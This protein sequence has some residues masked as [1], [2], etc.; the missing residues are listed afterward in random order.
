MKLIRSESIRSIYAPT[1]IT[2]CRFCYNSIKRILRIRFTR[3]RRHREFVPVTW[4][5][6][7]SVRTYVTRLKI[8]SAEKRGRT[9][10]LPP[11]TEKRRSDTRRLFVA[12]ISKAG[13]RGGGEKKG[14]EGKSER[15]EISA[16]L[17]YT[18]SL[19]RVVFLPRCSPPLSS[20]SA[21]AEGSVPIDPPGPSKGVVVLLGVATALL[22]L[23]SSFPTFLLSALSPYYSLST[24]SM[25]SSFLREIATR[26]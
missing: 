12:G 8:G 5:L 7:H 26:V 2:T 15:D 4:L 20:F 13:G 6:R 14:K 9:P 23:S 3:L 17:S 1:T 21:L 18:L 24:R 19:F 11:S 16:N 22:P 10:F 25:L